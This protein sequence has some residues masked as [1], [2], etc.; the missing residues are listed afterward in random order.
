MSSS[1]FLGMTEPVFRSVVVEWGRFKDVVRMDTAFC[2]RESRN[3]FLKLAFGK[4][5]SYDILPYHQNKKLETMLSWAIRKSARLKGLC[6]SEGFSCDAQILETFL[7]MSGAAVRW[8]E[9]SFHGESSL[10]CQQ[11]L[12]KVAAW[13]PNV[14]KLH[15]WINH[16]TLQWDST[17]LIL[18]KAFQN[19]TSLSFFTEQLSEQGLAK[20]LNCCKRLEYLQINSY[21]RSMPTE[22]AVPT[23]KNISVRYMTDAVLIAIGQRCAILERLHC[24]TWVRNCGGHPVTD[25]GVRAILEGCPLLRDTDVECATWISCALRMELVR[26]RRFTLLRHTTWPDMDNPLAQ[27]VMQASPELETVDF[28]NCTWVTDATLVVCALHCPLLQDITLRGCCQIT[29]DGVCA[30]IDKVGGNLRSLKL[31]CCGLLTDNSVEATARQCPLLRCVSCPFVSDAAVTKLAEGC[32]E[33]VYAN[34]S[35]TG[36][37]D[38][39]L[40]ALS[41][42]CT[43]LVTLNVRQCPSITLQ[44]VRAI[45]ER[46]TCLEELWL[47]SQ[48]QSRGAPPLPKFAAKSVHVHYVAWF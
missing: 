15:L 47:P 39:T 32:P 41:Q 31:G 46:C 36:A 7:M 16:P 3:V 38:G 23:L 22:L 28:E 25:S 37:G 26:R 45:A 19:M 18:V 43:K 9:S 1:I 17:F 2:S 21:Y 20:A 44:G 12:E 5:A 24:F 48:L 6:I 42:H 11:A 27:R 8:V 33:L 35:G 10:R 13:C 14:E 30:L 29:D 40:V 34:L 4:F